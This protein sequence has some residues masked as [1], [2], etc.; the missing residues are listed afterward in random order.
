MAK[1]SISPAWTSL[2]PVTQASSD[3][4]LQAKCQCE[5]G[6]AKQKCPELLATCFLQ[7]CCCRHEISGS[8]DMAPAIQYWQL[9]PDRKREQ[10]GQR[11]AAFLLLLFPMC[12][13]SPLCV[14]GGLGVSSETWLSLS[15]PSSG[16]TPDRRFSPISLVQ[17]LRH[18]TAS[19]KFAS[20]P[21]HELSG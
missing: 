20:H 4:W 11:H 17:P 2:L 10:G 14:T 21:E 7:F 19:R 5:R 13:D 3:G 16:L 8:G 15:S 1:L 6:A 12:K 9:E 18:Q